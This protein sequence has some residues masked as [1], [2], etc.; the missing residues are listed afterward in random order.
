MPVRKKYEDSCEKRIT[1][2]PVRR[3]STGREC[4]RLSRLGT[5]ALSG[6]PRYPEHCH[7][8]NTDITT[9]LV[10]IIL[11]RILGTINS[12]IVTILVM[13][14]TDITTFLVTCRIMFFCLNPGRPSYQMEAS[15]CCT[16]GWAT[17]WGVDLQW[18]RNSK[19]LPLRRE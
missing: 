10:T 2:I 11:V 19:L 17:N 3:K 16:F 18:A 1:R 5:S 12:D 6:T 13:L 7:M 15:S 14:N 8:I 4:T 9:I